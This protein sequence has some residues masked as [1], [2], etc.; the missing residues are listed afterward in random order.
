MIS[1]DNMFRILG[2]FHSPDINSKNSR[3]IRNDDLPFALGMSEGYGLTSRVYY[4]TYFRNDTP[5]NAWS[6]TFTY[7]APS[8]NLRTGRLHLRER[9]RTEFSASGGNIEQAEYDLADCLLR[10][11]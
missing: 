4:I 1:A 3:I 7:E 8:P 2:C 6:I 10:I 9:A 5:A 11:P